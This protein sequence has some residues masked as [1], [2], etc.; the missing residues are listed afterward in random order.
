MNFADE[1]YVRLYTADTVT[2]K[3]LGW[4]GQALLALAL[5]KFDRS[6]V[7]EFGKHGPEKALLVST[8]LPIELIKTG[9]QRILDEGIW[10]LEQDRLFW[11]RYIEAQTCSRSDKLRQRISRARKSLSRED[12]PSKVYFIQSECGGPIKIGVASFLPQRLAELQTA[13][14]DKLLVLLAIDGDQARE[15]EIHVQFASARIAGE[16]FNPTNELLS[17][18]SSQADRQSA[19]ES[20]NCHVSSQLSQVSQLVTPGE[21]RR[22]EARQ[23]ILD[24]GVSDARE[25]AE[26]SE[27]E[28]PTFE[29]ELP[30][31]DAS[32]P[33]VA[34]DAP[35]P[36]SDGAPRVTETRLRATSREL[37]S[38][39]RNFERS[40]SGQ[41]TKSTA[42]EA[43]FGVYRSE[44]GKTGARYDHKARDLFERLVDE[45][46]TPESVR[47]VVR[48]A[49]LDPWARDTAKLAAAPL[50]SSADQR[51]KY[52]AIAKCPPRAAG[53]KAPPQPNDP[54]NRYDPRKSAGVRVI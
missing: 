30:D 33:P 6:G 28:L 14:P 47:E 23:G 9:L 7:F 19:T 5:R 34:S 20:E 25:P 54:N 18:I 41:S 52:T 49:K 3:C 42:A 12:L 31:S 44:S 32:L 1:E 38:H 21:A 39:V 24:S 48:G 35:A 45:G 17:W 46:E 40:M 50:L 43:L 27:P 29:V 26:P 22:G 51:E 10:D 13:R 4:E 11:P 36:A 37:P 8:G 53:V 16:W 2:W 15:R